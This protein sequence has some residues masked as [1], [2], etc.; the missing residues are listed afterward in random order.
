MKPCEPSR[1]GKSNLRVYRAGVCLFEAGSLV[2]L[3]SH[4]LLF[5]QGRNEQKSK[6]MNPAGT[7]TTKRLSRET[8]V[9]QPGRAGN[10]QASSEPLQ[11]SIIEDV[12]TDPTIR[13][14]AEA[15]FPTRWGHFRI[16]GFEG[17]FRG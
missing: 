16:L 11:L 5:E 1:L 10:P 7:T 9:A 8:I 12:S 4:A 2:A 15:D 6:S 13:K 3:I 14:M 17:T